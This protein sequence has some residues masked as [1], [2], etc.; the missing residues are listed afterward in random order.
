MRNCLRARR[1]ALLALA[2]FGVNGLALAEDFNDARLK[3]GQVEYQAKRYRE[4]VDEF[5][6]A[7]FGYLDQPVLL[8]ECLVRLTLALAAAG[9]QADVDATLTRFL[10]VERR[11]GTYAKA[12][13]E[14][15]TRAA[16]WALLT[17]RLPPATIAGIPSLSKSTGGGPADEAKPPRPEKPASSALAAA[18]PPPAMSPKVAS[19]PPPAAAEAPPAGTAAAPAAKSTEVL[20]ESR[21]LIAAGKAVEAERTLSAAVNSN[22]G[23]RDLRL[24]LLEA[25]CLA[26]VYGVGAAQLPAVMPFADTEAVPMFYAAVVLYETGKPKEAKDYLKRAAPGV[27]GPLVDEYSKKILGQP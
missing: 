8:Q 18:A 9:K 2:L 24:A 4:A 19:P 23:D 26:R 27:S 3:A 16:F 11:F 20:A 13:L 22:P 25:A 12:N 5:R 10:E 17:K 1:A 21:K 14:P 7:A 15:D 6:V